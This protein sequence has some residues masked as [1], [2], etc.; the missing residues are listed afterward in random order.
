[1]TYLYLYHNN[2]TKNTLNCVIEENVCHKA[3]DDSRV[4]D[5]CVQSEVHMKVYPEV[6]DCR[7]PPPR[8]HRLNMYLAQPLKNRIFGIDSVIIFF[9]G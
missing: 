4:G 1:M 8:H 3:V 6:W 5:F 9:R 7:L 2:Y